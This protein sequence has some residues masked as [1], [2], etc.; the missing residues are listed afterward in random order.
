MRTPDKNGGLWFELTRIWIG[1]WIDADLNWRIWIDADLNWRI[2]IDGFD[3]TDLNWRIWIDGFELTY[4][5]WRDTLFIIKAIR[6]Y[7]VKFKCWSYFIVFYLLFLL[8]ISKILK[9]RVLFDLWPLK[10]WGSHATIIGV[11]L[12][13]ANY[14]N[15]SFIPL[16]FHIEQDFFAAI[17]LF[18][19]KKSVKKH[20][21]R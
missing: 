12:L 9:F 1:I 19:K 5:N 17:V 15:F 21:L 11:L 2:W 3:L 10:V 16:K 7:R 4:L 14:C 8:L 13:K 18:R 6:G 20:N